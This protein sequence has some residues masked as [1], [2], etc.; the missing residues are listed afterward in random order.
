MLMKVTSVCA[1]A[2]KQRQAVMAPHRLP[3]SF[4]LLKIA[5]ID[6]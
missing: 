6:I 3:Q 4:A 1:S 5:G 2:V